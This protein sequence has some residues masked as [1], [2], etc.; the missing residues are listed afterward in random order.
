[1]DSTRVVPVTDTRRCERVAAGINAA[2]KTPGR[3]RWLY[4][5]KAG[6]M[7]VALDRAWLKGSW[8]PALVLDWQ[9]VHAGSVNA[10]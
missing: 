9:Y 10:F 8:V 4:V 2:Y 6:S 1:M 7:Y 3:A 5:V